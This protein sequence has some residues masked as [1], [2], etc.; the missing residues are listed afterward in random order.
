MGIILFLFFF[1]E[2]ENDAGFQQAVRTSHG[3]R[4]PVRERE[5]EGKGRGLTTANNIILITQMTAKFP[6]TAVGARP[7][8]SSFGVSTVKSHLLLKPA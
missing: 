1:K 8:A 3:R 7:L 6:G 4:P 5:G 2:M